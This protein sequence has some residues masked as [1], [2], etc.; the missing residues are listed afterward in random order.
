MRL[1]DRILAI[2]KPI[3]V[4]EWWTIAVFLGAIGQL[5]MIRGLDVKILLLFF[6]PPFLALVF[7]NL[8]QR[9]S[10]RFIAALFLTMLSLGEIPMRFPRLFP[11]LGKGGESQLAPEY[12]R[13]LAWYII[14]YLL[15]VFLLLPLFLFTRGL[16]DHKRKRPAQFSKFTCVLGLFTCLVVGTGMASAYFEFLH[17]V[18][19]TSK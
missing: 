10:S 2:L 7:E 8:A 3:S 5:L 13:L 1:F 18:P 11:N 12:N 15:Y 19:A 16:I 17:R 14:V 9:K 4:L 6:Y